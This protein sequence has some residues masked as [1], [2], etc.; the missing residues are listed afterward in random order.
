MSETD[1]FLN[2]RFFSFQI[3]QLKGRKR[4]LKAL[5]LMLYMPLYA[6]ILASKAVI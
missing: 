1:C 3:F 5:C 4:L 2:T 6:F